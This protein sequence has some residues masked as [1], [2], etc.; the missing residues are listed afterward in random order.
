M[1]QEAIWWKMGEG[2]DFNI[3]EFWGLFRVLHALLGGLVFCL[4]PGKSKNNPTLA[5]FAKITANPQGGIPK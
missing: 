4:P 5:P 1:R 3:C 2:M